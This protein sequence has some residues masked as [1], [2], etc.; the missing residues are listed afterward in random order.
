MSSYSGIHDHHSMFFDERRN[1]CYAQAIKAAVNTDS[2]VL[3]LGAGLGLHGFMAARDGA[4]KVYLVEPASIIET[5]RQLVVDNNL[6]ACIECLSGKIEEVNLPQKVD[7]I[8]SVFTGN[9][10]LEEN[11]LPS[12]FYARDKYLKPGGK[13]IPERAIMQVVP[14]SLPQ[15]YSE[16]I[17]CWNE[18]PNKLDLN[19]GKVR[20]FASNSLFYDSPKNWQEQCLAEPAE[21]LDM[22]FMTA[23]EAACRAD[24]EVE[25]NQTGLCHGWL[26]WFK[27][28]LGEHW[29]STSPIE[30]QMHWRQVFLP[31][32][33]PLALNKG[34]ILSFELNRPEFGEW[35][36]TTGFGK[37]MQ[38]QSTFLS[39]PIS[40]ATLKKK[41]NGYQPLLSAKGNAARDVL[42]ALEGKQSTADI[43]A[44]V[45][46]AHPKL[47]PTRTLADEFVKEL[48]AHYGQ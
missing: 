23:T 45:M 15:Y 36:W 16:N 32:A 6:S 31:L 3:D 20:E 13:L 33:E 41:S 34:D 1:S 39:T 42:S 11:L 25:I 9:F 24:I 44:N 5:T 22:D 30:E 8:V 35:T 48:V 43:V 10:L 4:Q 46:A 19:L 38:R 12:L 21:L 7:V 47:F 40:P 27:M 28:R 14:V 37:Q 18:A 29:L 26:G 2:V 17:D